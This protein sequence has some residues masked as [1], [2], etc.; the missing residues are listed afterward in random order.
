MKKQAGVICL[1]LFAAVSSFA[2]TKT[3]GLDEAVQLGIQNS[4][5]LK[6]S[7]YKID[8][9]LARLDQSKDA[10]LPSAKVGFQYLHALML[11]RSFNIPGITQSP[12]ELPF[13]LPAYLGTLSVTEPIFAGNQ[14]KYARQSAD[15]V[16]QMSRL[17]ADKDK[18]DITYIIINAYINYNKILQN[19]QIV[20]QNMQDVDSKLTE[21][22]KYEGQGLA[23]K[24]DVLRF[25]LQKSQMQL[26]E[27]EL[28]NNRQIANYNMDVLL[29]LPDSTQIVLPDINY[30]LDDQPVF[31]DLFQQAEVNRR[32]LMDLSY[33][34]KISDI[35]V[36]KIQDQRLPTLAANFGG[37]YI[38]P[39]KKLIPTDHT[40]LAPITLGIAA[41]WDIGSLYTNKNKV[42]E[43][44]IQK[45]DLEMGKQETLDEI[46][47][48]V[49]QY[50]TLYLQSL[51]KIKLLEVAVTQAAENERITESK[52]RNNLVNTTDRIDAQTM[53][54]E[55]R[56]NLEL[57]KSDA[58]IAYYDMLKSTGKIQL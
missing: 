45:Q 21:I 49:N 47:K 42:K 3:L 52:F 56:V 23:T 54:Y 11:A 37:Y 22:N 8:E 17:D 2:Q 33:Q 9:A 29:G 43:V 12:L 44:V 13:D 28:E 40:V 1:L 10:V 50:F 25:E 41:S 48:Q 38:N 6:R 46:R 35:N 53:L 58:T 39:T 57:A 36:K 30:K 34:T 32:E 4:K 5:T 55:T 27:L 51:Q 18:E 20:A 7:Q 24:N 19:Q 26:T 31:A 16:V 14:L 15:L